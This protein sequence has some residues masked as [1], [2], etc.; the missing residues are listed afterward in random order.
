MN[1]SETGASIAEWQFEFQA[2][3]AQFNADKPLLILTHHDADGLTAAA[4]LK[5]GFDKLSRPVEVRILGRGENPWADAVQMELLDR[6]AGGLVVVDLGVRPGVIRR[7]TP[8]LLIDHHQPLGYPPGATVITGFG[9]DPTPTSAL[10]AYW[11]MRSLADLE[12]LLWLVGIS[13]IGDMAEKSGFREFTL[14]K[15]RHGITAL[16]EATSLLNAAR[17]AS[18]GNAQPA[19]DLLTKAAS[20]KEVTSGNF[21]ETQLLLQ[22]RAEVASALQATRRVAPKIKGDVA[23]ILFDSPCQIHPLI[24]Q[25]WKDRLHKNVVIGANKGYRP[26]WV[27]FSVRSATGVNLID[28]LKERA[29]AA[30]DENYGSGHIQAT[31][32][33]LRNDAWNEFVSGLGFGM[34]MHV[35]P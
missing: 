28:F 8:T 29:P 1:V 15:E 14:A 18:S 12:D 2:A 34:E 33:A 31:G 13:I 6:E 5:K 26:G 20:P 19:F 7:D 30:A 35:N 24:A 17:R 9:A 21:R 27:H 10:L 16:R 11:C 4:I 32:G 25:Q 22:A 23:L 3:L